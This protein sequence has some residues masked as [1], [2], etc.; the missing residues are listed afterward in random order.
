MKKYS[1]KFW[2]TLNKTINLPFLLIVQIVIISLL[3]IVITSAVNAQ[4]KP[5][6]GLKELPK[7][8]RD[9]VLLEIARKTILR[10]G[11]DYY[12]INRHPLI[13]KID[14]GQDGKPCRVRYV[15]KYYYKDEFYKDLPDY[16]AKECFL[17]EVS[18]W[19]DNGLA[20]GVMFDGLGRGALDSDVNRNK[21]N[22]TKTKRKKQ[23]G[24]G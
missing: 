19:E 22:P 13:E 10:Y 12:E 14:K 11:P 1:S 6:Y 21:K 15:V 8:K 4:V 23:S 20:Y 5:V 2:K 17:V 24:K 16:I 7:V 3:L 18:I 9:S